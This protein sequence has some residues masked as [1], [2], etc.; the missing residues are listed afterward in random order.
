MRIPAGPQDLTA[1]WLATALRKGGTIER[2]AVESFSEAAPAE[3]QGY[4]GQ[5][6]RVTLNY[7]QSDPGAPRTVIAKFSSSTLELRARALYGYRREIQFYRHLADRLELRTPA[8]YYG[9]SDDE[10]ALRVILMEDLAPA[11]S[12][13]KVVGASPAQA[14]LAVHQLAHLHGAWWES[15]ALGEI[16]WL[17][18][19]SELPSPEESRAEYDSWWPIF[20]QKIEGRHELPGLLIDLGEGF[21]RHRSW[22]EQHLFRARPLTLVHGDWGLS[23][24]MFGTPEGGAPF[25]AIDWGWVGRSR[26]ASELAW[27]IGGGLR[28]DTR[29]AI[30]MDLL[31][32]YHRILREHGVL[33]YSFDDCLRDY[34]LALMQRFRSIVST[35]AVMPFQAH[36]IQEVMDYSLPR[37][38]AALLDHDASAFVQ[39]HYSIRPQIDLSA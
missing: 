5:V 25:A 12:G 6:A 3:G 1:S 33:K 30:E 39:C 34:R 27:F 35:I 11:Q 8:F 2:T 23:N 24:L 26:G 4:F 28:I 19:Y 32:D 18:D 15:P 7:D 36:Q 10:T 37:N 9:D 21:G 31:R 17:Q 14:A 13:S 16:S 20:L 22:I 29:R 38:I